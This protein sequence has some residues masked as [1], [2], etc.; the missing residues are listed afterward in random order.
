MHASNYDAQETKIQERTQL[1][2]SNVMHDLP[3]VHTWQHTHLC[4]QLLSLACFC[5]CSQTLTRPTTHTTTIV[6]QPLTLSPASHATVPGPMSLPPVAGRLSR[7]GSA[8]Q[9]AARFGRVALGNPL[10][11]GSPPLPIP[12]CVCWPYRLCGN[13]SKMSFTVLCLAGPRRIP[14]HPFTNLCTLKHKRLKL[15]RIPVPCGTIEI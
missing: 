15:G 3:V 14:K 5:L 10:L 2:S 8:P 9:Q 4:P 6:P 1:E 12:P 13:L 11:L 7:C